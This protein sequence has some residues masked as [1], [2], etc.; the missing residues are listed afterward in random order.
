MRMPQAPDGSSMATAKNSSAVIRVARTG[1]PSSRT[2]SR[3]TS[4]FV[5]R[6]SGSVELVD[7]GLTAAVRGD[8]AVYLRA[9]LI[10][11]AQVLNY[12]VVF[13][14]QITRDTWSLLVNVRDA[15]GA[16]LLDPHARF[17]QVVTLSP[18][19]S[20]ERHLQFRRT[21][22]PA[23][24]RERGDAVNGLDEFL[25]FAF[26]YMEPRGQ[27]RPGELTES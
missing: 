19:R 10:R 7:G 14:E 15:S 8:A 17:R 25:S 16:S 1:A 22:R 9:T 3:V 26:G 27:G 24:E 20:L 5:L 23:D 12:L 4:A 6:T 2:N 21:L 11:T 18:R 13:G